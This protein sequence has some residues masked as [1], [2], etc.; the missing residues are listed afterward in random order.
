MAS[1]RLGELLRQADEEVGQMPSLPD[2]LPE[3]VARRAAYC[4]RRRRLLRGSGVGVLAVIVGVVVLQRGARDGG[5]VESTPAEGDGQTRD[6]ALVQVELGRLRME[7]ESRLAVA[8]QLIRCREHEER[9]AALEAESTDPDPVAA[10]N[11]AL[12]G[13]AS[14]LVQQA[15]RLHAGLHM[16]ASAEERYRDAIRL[17][18]DTLWAGVAREMLAK[19][20]KPAGGLL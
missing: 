16:T 11:E 8:R 15:N 14:V 6:I 12:E 18:P 3:R 10:A 20:Q 1:D 17:F 4:R 5:P 13:A 7:A 2:D 9:L 19:M